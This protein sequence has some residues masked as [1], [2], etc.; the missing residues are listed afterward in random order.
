[1]VRQPSAWG[2]SRASWEINLGCNYRCKHCYL[3]LKVNSGMPL[4]DKLA[5]LKV[6]A[7]AGVLWLQITGGEPTVDK[8]F[9]ASYRHA[10]GLGMRCAAHGPGPRPGPPAVARGH[11]LGPRHGRWLSAAADDRRR[12]LRPA[13]PGRRANRPRLRLHHDGLTP[14]FLL[15][16][17][18]SRGQLRAF[19]A[20]N[21]H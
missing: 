8:D 1:M 6:M 16:L 12:S 4:A 7:E 3:G 17:R 5:C 21:L 19:L 11:A 13:L 14:S 2:Y 10:Y 20:V 18:M 15:M 9:I